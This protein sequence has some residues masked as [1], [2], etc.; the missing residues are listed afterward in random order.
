LFR[1]PPGIRAIVVPALPSELLELKA[2]RITFCQH[3]TVHM[4]SNL[5]LN[6]FLQPPNLTHHTVSNAT[7]RLQLR[8]PGQSSTMVGKIQLAVPLRSRHHVGIAVCHA[9]NLR[10]LITAVRRG[11]AVRL[12]PSIQSTI[13]AT[14]Q[15]RPP[16]HDGFHD[17][18]ASRAAALVDNGHSMRL[19]VWVLLR[20]SLDHCRGGD[21]RLQNLHLS[22][23]ILC[24][25]MLLPC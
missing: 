21:S 6:C 22:F 14:S 23:K 11:A 19:V 4:A 5:H 15:D 18:K 8:T 10:L 25:A 17:V 12:T 2:G 1:I 3:D 24:S 16:L 7:K 9:L 13:L 20:Y